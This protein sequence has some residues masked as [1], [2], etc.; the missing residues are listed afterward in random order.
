MTPQQ[1]VIMVE[2]SPPVALT[3]MSDAARKNLL[4]LLHPDRFGRDTVWVKRATEAILRLEGARRGIG[5]SPNVAVG[6]WIVTAPVAKGDLADIHLAESGDGLGL[7]KIAHSARDNDLLDGEYKVLSQIHTYTPGAGH[8]TQYTPRP[9][10]HFIASGRAVNVFTRATGYI[11]LEDIRKLVDFEFRHVVW[12]MNRALSALG[13]IHRNGVIHGAVNDQH[14][15]YEPAT[16]NMRLIDWCYSV[17]IGSPVK[18]VVKSRRSFYPPEVFRKIA[19]GPHT[20]LFMLAQAM[21]RPDLT[22]IPRAFRD[23]FELCLVQSPASRPSDAWALQ[24]RWRQA[25]RKEYGEPQF[26]PLVLP[27]H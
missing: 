26:V 10:N 20:D 15:L 22:Y 19:C 6:A 7:L 9:L 12:M 14:L 27:V 18:A 21:F 17:P 11:A 23:L 4:M 3:S 13:Y 25:A 1:A 8:Y 24:D 2:N 16:H 5:S